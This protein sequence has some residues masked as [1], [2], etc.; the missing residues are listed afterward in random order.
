MQI[1][2]TLLERERLVPR[3]L[4]STCLTAASV[5]APNSQKNLRGSSRPGGLLAIRLHWWDAV[6]GCSQALPG[7][8][9]R[10]GPF[11]DV[12]PGPFKDAS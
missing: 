2:I 1:D 10:N 12:L 6:D 7:L 4:G 9:W 8:T 5:Y 11:R 3:S